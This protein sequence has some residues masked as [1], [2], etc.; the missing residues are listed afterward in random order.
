MRTT[1]G[2]TV[3]HSLKAKATQ[4]WISTLWLTVKR[5]KEKLGQDLSDEK[6]NEPKKTTEDKEVP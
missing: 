2:G 6:E 1:C 4:S 3:N 5:E